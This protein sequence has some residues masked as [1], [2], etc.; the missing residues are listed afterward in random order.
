VHESDSQLG[1]TLVSTQIKSSFTQQKCSRQEG[2]S[3]THGSLERRFEHSRFKQRQE[4]E[5]LHHPPFLFYKYINV[6]MFTKCTVT[7]G[8]YKVNVY[9]CQQDKPHV[10]AVTHFLHARQRMRL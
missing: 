9:V 7:V 10:T 4:T 8:V 5:T 6:V 1:E 2:I 3:P